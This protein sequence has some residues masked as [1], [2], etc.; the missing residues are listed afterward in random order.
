LGHVRYEPLGTPSRM[1]GGTAERLQKQSK[2]PLLVGADF[3][4]G[5]SNAREF[6]HGM[7][8]QHGLPAARD[9]DAAKFEGAATAREA[10]ALGVHWVFAPVADVNNNAET[11]HH[12]RSYGIEPQD[13][14]SFVK[15]YIA[16]AHSD[17]KHLVLVTAKHFPG[18]G[19]TSQDSHMELARLEASENA[20]TRWNWRLSAPPSRPGGHHHDSAH[21]CA[22]LEPKEIP[23]RSPA[24]ILTDLLRN[25]MKFPGSS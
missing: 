4:R 8:V 25:Q 16:G 10:R 13:V 21:G 18:H 14:S 19:D 20:S 11:D 3:E 5:A 24:A 23:P 12:I 6:N 9:W 22:A 1:H 7:A 15:S 2:V 17:P